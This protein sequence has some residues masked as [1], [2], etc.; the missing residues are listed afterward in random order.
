MQGCH[1]PGNGQ[2]KI[3]L[4]PGPD[5]GKGREFYFESRKIDFLKKSQGN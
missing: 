5:Q 2:G 4:H 1:R 3:N